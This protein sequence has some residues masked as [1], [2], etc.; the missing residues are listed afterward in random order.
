[1]SRIAKNPIKISNEIDENI[2]FITKIKH[3]QPS[4]IDFCQ[5]VLT[6]TR[7]FILFLNNTT[8]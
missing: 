7:K 6:N 1:M 2:L 4:D 3:G 8:L 5:D